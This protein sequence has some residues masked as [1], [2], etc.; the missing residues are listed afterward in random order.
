MSDETVD[1]MIDEAQKQIRPSL[2]D[3]ASE[4]QRLVAMFAVWIYA[5]HT[6]AQLAVAHPDVAQRLFEDFM[7]R[8][9]WPVRDAMAEAVSGIA[10]VTTARVN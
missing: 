7:S 1:R 10:G 4:D 2:K 6:G 8:A 3:V 9:P 5:F